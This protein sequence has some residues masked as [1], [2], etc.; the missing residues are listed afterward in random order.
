[1]NSTWKANLLKYGI[2][3]AVGLLM[4][5]LYFWLRVED[6]S[7]LAALTSVELYLMICDAF[8][9]PGLTILMCGC[10]V[11]LSNE[12]AFNGVGYVVSFAIRTLIPGK[13]GHERYSDYLERKNAN[14]VKG[15]GFLFPVGGI[16]MV[17]ALVFMALYHSV[18]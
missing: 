7:E 13:G 12:G 1:M 17:V 18:Y 4:V 8:T 14:R 15:Y 5:W 6:L 9:I 2:T 16:F 10:L 3:S 11:W